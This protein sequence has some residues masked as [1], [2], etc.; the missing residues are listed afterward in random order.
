MKE[1]IEEIRKQ[2]EADL[3]TIAEAGDFQRVRDLYFSRKSGRV[4]LLMKELGK[5][6]GDERRDAGKLINDFKD[7]AEL[8]LEKYQEELKRRA[9]ATSI[10]RERIDITMPGR[11]T[12]PGSAHPRPQCSLS[13]EMAAPVR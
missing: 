12:A 2:F 6:S 3:Q 5:L 11:R 10:E 1:T 13:S 7:Y 8:E 9:E 4:T